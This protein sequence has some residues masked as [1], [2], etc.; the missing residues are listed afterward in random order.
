MTALKGMPGEWM[1]EFSRPSV[2]PEKQPT[3]GKTDTRRVFVLRDLV[4]EMTDRSRVGRQMARSD[5][6]RVQ[7]PDS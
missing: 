2:F 1:S 6:N 5:A 4:R 7:V 3:T